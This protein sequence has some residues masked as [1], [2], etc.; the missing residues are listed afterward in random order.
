MAKILIS[1]KNESAIDINLKTKD[2]AHTVTVPGAMMD[3]DKK[4]VPGTVE[5]EE[6]I[7]DAAVDASPVVAHYF[8]SGML[9]K[10]GGKTA[11][12]K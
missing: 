4:L 2:G 12:K 3:D 9:T 6:S 7:V 11:V 10:V 1:N 8:D 5:A